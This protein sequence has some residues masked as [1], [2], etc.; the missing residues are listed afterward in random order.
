MLVLAIVMLGLGIIAG[1]FS[2][3]GAVG[4]GAVPFALGFFV[5]AAVAFTSHFTTRSS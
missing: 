4:A 2:A 5:L 3:A 1:G